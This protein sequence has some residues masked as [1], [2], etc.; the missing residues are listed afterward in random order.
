[1]I[2]NEEKQ[3]IK[4]DDITLSFDDEKKIFINNN[5][6][7][8]RI[9]YKDGEP[10]FYGKDLCEMLGITART[11]KKETLDSLDEEF[12]IKYKNIKCSEN[13]NTFKGIQKTE[14]FVNE[15]GFYELMA[16]KSSKI[17]KKFRKWIF[18]EVLPSLRKHGE[19]KIKK[20]YQK[21]IQ[22][23]DKK[24]DELI[25]ICK[26]NNIDI[27]K[28]VQQNKQIISKMDKIIPKVPFNMENNQLKQHVII[29]KINNNNCDFYCMRIQNRNL[30]KTKKKLTDKYD[31][32]D[33]FV[34]LSDEP[35][36]IKF[37]NELFKYLNKKINKFENFYFECNHNKFS[38]NVKNI[39]LKNLIMR[40]HEKYRKKSVVKQIKY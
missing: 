37:K 8:I 29:Y 3:L 35:N 17:G 13:P 33:E 31:V 25:N 9:I 12:T 14:I 7:H 27:N 1:M 30:K 28:V 21:E 2:M 11:T 40:C 15:A 39:V 18:G 4:F 20:Y 36:P 24:I 22:T 19:Y 26:K 38:T 23:R 34:K 16:S 5:G 6:K 10:W 32:V